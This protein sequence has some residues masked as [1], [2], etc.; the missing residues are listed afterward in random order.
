MKECA[1]ALVIQNRWTEMILSIET[2]NPTYDALKGYI[3][4]EAN[5]Q[6]IYEGNSEKG[7]W[8][9]GQATE[10]RK[11]DLIGGLMRWNILIRSHLTGRQKK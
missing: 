2:K 9:A 7:Y 11:N 1:A 3:N 6:F 5:K 10:V 8:W 4:V